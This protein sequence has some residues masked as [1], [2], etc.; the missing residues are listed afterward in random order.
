MKFVCG[1]CWREGQ[2]SEPDKNLKYCTA[3]A[4]HS[5]TKE[6][7][8][9]LVKSFEKKKWVVVRPLPFS[10]TYPQQYDMC[11][12]VMKQKKCHYIGN[13]S[14]AHSLEERDVWTYMKNNS[15]RDMQQMYELWLELTNQNRRTDTSAVTPPPEDKQVTLTAEY[16]ES[17]VGQRMSEGNDLWRL[18][19]DRQERVALE[20][21]RDVETGLVL[22]PLLHQVLSPV[23]RGQ[24]GNT[25]YMNTREHTAHD[26]QITATGEH[27]GRDKKVTTQILICLLSWSHIAPSGSH[28]A[29]TASSTIH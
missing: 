17:M 28:L 12:H 23:G 13:C 20:P 7:R 9:L 10:R 19:R 6:R 15:L 27:K 21:Q 8:V 2:V 24:T 26:T 4:R 14:F 16:T 3:K 29:D 18:L 5:W 22:S 25:P 1:Q 11:V